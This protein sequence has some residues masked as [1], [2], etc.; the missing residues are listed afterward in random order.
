M[1]AGLPKNP[2]NPS[3][4]SSAPTSQIEFSAA[5]NFIT[6]SNFTTGDNMRGLNACF[7]DSVK[8]VLERD[9]AANFSKLFRQYKKHLGTFT[10]TSASEESNNESSESDFDYLNEEVTLVKTV[11]RR[12]KPRTFSFEIQPDQE[13]QKPAKVEETQ[14]PAKVNGPAESSTVSKQIIDT[15]I[16]IDMSSK[17]NEKLFT[18]ASVTKQLHPVCDKTP[19]TAIISP[20]QI[21]PVSERTLGMNNEQKPF[22]FGMS[23][24]QKPFT[25]GA[26]V[27]EKPFTFSTTTEH[28]I[29]SM[30]ASAEEKPFTFKMSSGQKPF[31]FGAATEQKPS[32]FSANTEQKSFTFGA[33]TEGNPS[34]LGA[35]AEEKP[36]LGVAIEQ[37]PFTFGTAT[38]Q[39]PFTFGATAEQKPFSFGATNEQKPFTFG[40]TTE[41][42]P[43]TFGATTEQKP[44]S[45]GT[46]AEQKPF[47]FEASSTL[48]AFSLN[49]TP[50]ATHKTDANS[51]NDDAEIP[52]E[53]A[54]NFNLTRSSS[55][56]LKTGAGEENETCQHEERCK[57]YLLNNE[58][59]EWSDL[60]VGIFKINRFMNAE[61]KSRILCRA[62]GSGKVTLNVL[63]TS[64]GT[65]ASLPEGKKE[66]ALMCIGA[67]GH[68]EKYLVRVKTVEQ[69]AAIN[70][71]LQ[72]E[73][74]YV[75][76]FKA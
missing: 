69:A 54:E 51:D 55:E 43:F 17:P 26:T 44:F 13:A 45:F 58:T 28:K 10:E 62:E 5:S 16:T 72:T 50:M 67:N 59:K 2:F 61:G 36:N 37:K 6:Q 70:S 8:Q 52:A 41:Q 14:N 73:I 75:Q 32:S 15:P 63:I 74:I 23:S 7:I 24:E 9:P 22:T 11:P 31:S 40:A 12:R 64:K 66:I 65:E 60:G 30:G 18:N 34:S 29:S 53:E 27:E 19:F 42:K 49:T 48:P 33:T 21:E 71:A 20:D 39:K 4:P 68:P 76:S 35:G 1:F 46:T 25:F 47:S 3:A 57:I 38:E 56:Q